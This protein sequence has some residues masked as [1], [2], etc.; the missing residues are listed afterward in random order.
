MPQKKPN[1]IK[2]YFSQSHSLLNSLVLVLPLLILYQVGLLL[3]GFK[4]ALNGVDFVSII[5]LSYTGIWGLLVFNLVLVIVMLLGA[6]QLRKKHRFNPDF[7]LP[8]VLE[9]MV[10]AILL[11]VVIVLIMRHTFPMAGPVEE[12]GGW[13]TKVTISLGAGVYEEL[14]FRLG[15]IS[16][17]AYVFVKWVK[18]HKATAFFAAMVISSFLFSLAHYIGTPIEQYGLVYRF[19]AGLIFALLFKFR[20]FAIAVYTHAFYDI[21]VLFSR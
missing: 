14:F 8:M 1:Q 15:L 10:Y 2:L 5:L 20:S 3:V 18:V 7:F 21:F 13:L 16:L 17:F 11:G 4:Q 12:P 6:W 19:L 9:S